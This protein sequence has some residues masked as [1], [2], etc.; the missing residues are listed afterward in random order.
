[1]LI[2]PIL[3]LDFLSHLFALDSYLAPKEPH[4]V[5]LSTC[6]RVMSS[7][8]TMLWMNWHSGDAC[9]NH[10]Y[11]YLSLWGEIHCVSIILTFWEIRAFLCLIVRGHSRN[12]RSTIHRWGSEYMCIWYLSLSLCLSLSLS[13]SCFSCSLCLFLVSPSIYFRLL[14]LW[15]FLN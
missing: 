10:I 14:L 7:I 3:F 4:N 12:Y 13:L 11:K 8:V 2:R 1:M 5:S 15:A 9:M 6:W